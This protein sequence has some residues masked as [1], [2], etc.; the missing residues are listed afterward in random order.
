MTYPDLTPMGDEWPLSSLVWGRRCGDGQC[1]DQISPIGG[2]LIQKARLI[3]SDDIQDLVRPL[4]P[5]EPIGPDDLSSFCS[6]L[7]AELSALYPAILEAVQWETAFIPGDCEEMVDG[8]LNYVQGFPVYLNSLTNTSLTDLDYDD[9]SGPRRITLTDLPWG[10]IA[11]I[12]PQNAFMYLA[13]TCLLNALATGNRVIVRAPVQS[14]R[15]AALLSLAVERAQPW[16]DRISVVL[17]SARTFLTAV[18]ESAEPMLIHYLGSSAHAPDIL[19]T[20]FQSGNQALIDG[21]GNAWVW[22]DEDMPLDHACDVLTGGAVRYNGQTCTSIN[23]AIIHPAIYDR[24]KDRLAARWKGL[25]YGNPLEGDVEVGPLMDE[26]QAEHCL[27]QIES[28]GA[29]ILAGGS[30]SGNLLAPTLAAEPSEDSELVSEGLFGCALW[31][32]PGN[33]DR[34]A[35]LWRRNR[36]PLCAGV[37]SGSD[38]AQSLLRRLPNLARLTVN[39]DPS[40]EYM[41]E[42]WGGYPASG[43]N[44]VGHW[45]RKYLRTVQVDGSIPHA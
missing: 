14:A 38:C 11:A 3:G 29:E 30:R 8:T 5:L 7:H 17:V 16:T 13:A 44:T 4:P 35:E 20:C 9:G 32:A 2:K 18:R 28:S 43:M 22:V 21:E 40:I 36:Y 19:G 25:A 10:T 26:A 1:V 27:H 12:L 33:M 34:F 45:H 31:I 37:L 23:G 24:L 39:G 15:S 6:R 42:P 41:Y